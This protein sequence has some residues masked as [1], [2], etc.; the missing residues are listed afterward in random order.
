MVIDGKNEYKVEE[1]LDSHMRYDHLK[2]LIEWK[3]YNTSHNS[4]EVHKQVHA[5]LKIA[6]FHCNNPSAAQHINMAIF[7][8]IPF[9]RADLVTSWRSW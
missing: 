4:W 3:G 6:M 8:S 7:D 5:R 2:Y 1:I 9:T